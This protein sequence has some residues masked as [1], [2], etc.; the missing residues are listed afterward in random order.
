MCERYAKSTLALKTSNAIDLAN[1]DPYSCLSGEYPRLIDE[2]Q[3]A[4]DIWNCIKD[5]LGEHTT[6][7]KI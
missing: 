1:A 5:D 4:P 6:K 2:W 3:K 7:L